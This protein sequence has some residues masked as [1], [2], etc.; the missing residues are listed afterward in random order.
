MNSY[1][2]ETMHGGRKGVCERGTS[3]KRANEPLLINP[4]L[5][6]CVW[7]AETAKVASST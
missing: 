6:L 7:L 2:A 4:T 3:L 5:G 1:N